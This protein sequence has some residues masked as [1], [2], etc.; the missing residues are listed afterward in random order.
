MGSSIL[1]L[2]M[3]AFTLLVRLLTETWALF[4]MMA[5]YLLLGFVLSGFLYV[6][7]PKE[8]LVRHLGKPGLGA[9]FKAALFGIPLPLC[10]C[11]VIPAALS[12]RKQGASK[13]ATVSFLISTPEIGIDSIMATYSLMGGFLALIRPLCSALTA[14]ITG[15]A[16]NLLDREASAV[17]GE[18]VHRHPTPQLFRTPRSMRKIISYGLRDHLGG[19]YRWLLIGLILA[20]AVTL[21]LPNHIPQEHLSSRQDSVHGDLPFQSLG[22]HAADFLTPVPAS[23]TGRWVREYLLGHNELLCML[24][25]VLIG[26]PLYICATGSIPLAMSFMQAGLSP[27][28]A[29]VFLLVGPATNV[30]TVVMA[31]RY[32]GRRCTLIYLTGIISVGLCAGYAI[33]DLAPYHGWL[34]LPAPSIPAHEHGTGAAL[35]GWTCALIMAGAVTGAAWIDLRMAW[36][37]RVGG[38]AGPRTVTLPVDG[39]TCGHCKATVEGA[40]RAI[41]GVLKAE[42]NVSAQRVELTLDGKPPSAEALRAAVE[43][44][45]YQVPG[46]G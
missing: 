14:V 1:A 37:A 21:A 35:L 25:M 2:P 41:P 17:P 8:R 6:Y 38:N 11:G 39:M 13:G 44:A 29:F 5:P 23:A 3:G 26:V 24:L 19:V 30:T 40:L 36:R 4:F 16:V 43:A 12:L 22:R 9:V 42:A 32:L 31:W 45:G 46:N 20:A 18:P 34:S 28:A 33:N 7:L 15:C 27:G 10:S